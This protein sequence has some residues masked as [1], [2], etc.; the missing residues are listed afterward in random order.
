MGFPIKKVLIVEDSVLFRDLIRLVLNSLGVEEVVEADDGH[1]ALE[2]LKTFAAGMVVMDWMMPGMDGIECTQRIRWASRCNREVPIVMVSCRDGTTDIQKAIE[3]GV[4]SY[5]VK[6]TSAT[7]LLA[8]FLAAIP[9]PVTHSRTLT[10]S[11]DSVSG[12][13]PINIGGQELC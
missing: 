11:P 2:I 6:P 1:Q 8:G 13:M 4:N 7:R 3:S 12:A 10:S 9:A 5:V